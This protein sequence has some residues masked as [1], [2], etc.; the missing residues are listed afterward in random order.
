MT[1]EKLC[2][3][4]AYALN[5]FLANHV[6]SPR[7]T[8]ITTEKSMPDQRLSGVTNFMDLWDVRDCSVDS[9]EKALCE[10]RLNKPGLA[11]TE[12]QIKQAHGVL[13]KLMLSQNTQDTEQTLGRVLQN[14]RADLILG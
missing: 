1:L 3:I 8:L 7:R 14:E 9:I 10:L 12:E 4:F 6:E 11:Y 13:S 2:C 5:H